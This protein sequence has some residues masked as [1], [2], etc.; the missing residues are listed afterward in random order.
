MQKATLFGVAFFYERH[1]A[2]GRSGR[3]DNKPQRAREDAEDLI[4]RRIKSCGY[5]CRILIL[6]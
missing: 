5:C 1:K 4:E 3:M 2:Q 6:K